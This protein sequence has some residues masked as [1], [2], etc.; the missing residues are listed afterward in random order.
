M[1]SRRRAGQESLPLPIRDAGTKTF[2]FVKLR[3]SAKSE[4]SEDADLTV[5]MV[6]IPR[7]TR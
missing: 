5:Q 7:G 6:R 3:E 2:D 4:P 1:L